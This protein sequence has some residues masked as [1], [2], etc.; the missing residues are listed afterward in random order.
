MRGS[1]PVYFRL[2]SVSLSLL[3]QEQV[4]VSVAVETS[5]LS[6]GLEKVPHPVLQIVQL[7]LVRRMARQLLPLP[8]PEETGPLPE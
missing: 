8:L 6:L 7:V 3:Q 1:R 4:L 5:L 2:A